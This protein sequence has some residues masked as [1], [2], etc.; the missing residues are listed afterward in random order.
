MFKK[1]NSSK[2]LKDIIN[3]ISEIDI[4]GY[5]FNINH[6]PVLINS[7]F[8]KDDKPSFS[9]FTPD[10]NKI[11]YKDFANGD[12]G[13]LYSLLGKM[14]NMDF[15]Q[16]IEKIVNDL[17]NASFEK[18]KVSKKKKISIKHTS[19]DISIKI[20][21]WKDYDLEYWKSYGISLKWLKFGN[22]YPISHIFIQKNKETVCIPAEKYAY[23]YVEFKDAVTTIKIYQP[24]SSNFKWMSK[25]N[26]SVWD[27]WTKLP[28]TGENLIITSSRKDALCIWEN[29]GIPST[30]LQGEGY[31]PKEKVIDEL[32]KRFTNIYVLFDNDFQAEENHGRIYAENFCNLFKL[33]KIEIPEEYKSKDP[34]DLYKNHG[35][36]ILKQV[37]N[38]L[39]N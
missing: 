15:P 4:L 32:K 8:R 12:S 21:E 39:I 31:L 23:A 37:I 26:A 5:Y 29:T 30:S 10:D 35:G 34:S 25:H 20:R 28:Q 2:S 3:S 27:L 33:K 36:Q 22:V 18:I 19:S 11:L 16:V 38:N 13:N 1:G 6:L 9:I 7:P 17:N 14:W 24:F